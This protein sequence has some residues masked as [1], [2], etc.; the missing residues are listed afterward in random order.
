MSIVVLYPCLVRQPITNK[1]SHKLASFCQIIL[2][3]SLICG[4][5]GCS[6]DA[7]LV[8]P[9]PQDF[10]SSLNTTAAE[11]Y[12]S[13]SYDGRYLAFASDRRGNRGIWLYDLQSRRLVPLPGLNQPGIV[14][15]EPDI[16]ADG[17]YLVYVSEQSGKRGIFVYDR[18]SLK[19]ENLTQN[20][21]GEVRHP[22]ISGNGRFIAFET[23]RT[24][25]W[26]MVIY[27]R[28]SNAEVSIP[29]IGDR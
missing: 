23:N 17:R 9:P 22:S 27:D 7:S 11:Q 19:T 3:T 4:L 24:G 1:H 12:A 15:D 25:Q 16:S 2:A 10:G 20:W 5:S 26:D 29:K 28:G 21:L 14:Q 18:I 8:A 6:S 13:F